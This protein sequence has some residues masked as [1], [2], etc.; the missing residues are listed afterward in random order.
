MRD[1][2]AGDGAD[3]C[4][5]A[6]PLLPLDQITFDQGNANGNDDVDVQVSCTSGRPG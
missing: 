5:V 3:P 2:P 6:S 1:E 4:A